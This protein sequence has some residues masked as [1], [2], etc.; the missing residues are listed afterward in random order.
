MAPQFA[1]VQKTRFSKIVACANAKNHLEICGSAENHI[2][3]IESGGDTEKRTYKGTA[4]ISGLSTDQGLVIGGCRQLEFLS[5]SAKSPHDTQIH[6]N[7]SCRWQDFQAH[8][9]ISGL[10]I[11]QEHCTPAGAGSLKQRQVT[12]SAQHDNDNAKQSYKLGLP[13]AKH[14]LCLQKSTRTV[15]LDRINVPSRRTQL[16]RNARERTEPNH[17]TCHSSQ[18]CVLL[19]AGQGPTVESAEELDMCLQFSVAPSAWSGDH[20]TANS[21]DP[22][23]VGSLLGTGS[24]HWYTPYWMR[25]ANSSGPSMLRHLDHSD[26]SDGRR[27]R[28]GF[29]NGSVSQFR[30]V[31]QLA[32]TAHSVRLQHISR[33][34]TPHIALMAERFFRVP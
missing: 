1:G 7:S 23:H 17:V 18:A 19:R 34:R 6:T 25:A 21:R 8:G 31:P 14:R 33:L 11:N 12:A 5:D 13:A 26:R 22:P 29:A 3:K 28:L 10:R 32:V 30:N 27:T 16:A 20:D 4:G 24:G 9:G 15:Q 2:F